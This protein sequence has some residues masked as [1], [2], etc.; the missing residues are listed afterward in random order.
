MLKGGL[1]FFVLNLRNGYPGI[2][3]SLR[4]LL[5]LPLLILSFFNSPVFGQEED[6][7]LSLGRLSF[8]TSGSYH[9]RPWD[10]YNSSLALVE[11]AVRYDPTY[12]NPKGSYEKIVGDMGTGLVLSYRLWEGVHIE[13]LGGLTG[14]GGAVRLELPRPPFSASVTTQELSLRLVEWGLGVRSRFPLGD[15]FDLHTSVHVSRASGKLRYDY[16]Y[17]PSERQEYLFEADLRDEKTAVRAAVEVTYSLF[18][19]VRLTG[20][21]EY[22]WL[23]FDNLEGGGKEIY[24]EHSI[25]YEDILPFR[26]TLA[27]RKGYFFGLIPS[28]GSTIRNPHLMRTIWSR[29]ELYSSWWN[30]LEAASLDLSSFGIRIGVRYEFH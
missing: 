19:P 21:I 17:I 20:G 8:S 2:F 10:F 28:S 23:R 18:G 12:T 7:W 13:G 6:P 27:Q 9:F 15:G 4:S 29:T 26:A 5:L 16:A 25:P 24:R 30:N 11:N 1:I 22:R 3:T 14:T